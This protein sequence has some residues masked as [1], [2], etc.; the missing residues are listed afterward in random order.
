MMT[1]W[2]F[3]TFFIFP[4]IG[5]NHPNWL[6]FFR[7]VQTTNQIRV[8]LL[9]TNSNWVFILFVWKKMEE[10]SNVVEESRSFL[11]ETRL[12][13]GTRMKS[14]MKSLHWWQ[15][16]QLSQRSLLR[17]SNT[18]GRFRFTSA[19]RVKTELRLATSFRS[20]CSC[21]SRH[22]NILHDIETY[23]ATY[24]NILAGSWERDVVLTDLW[25]FM[26]VSVA[27][28]QL[29]CVCWVMGPLQ[30]REAEPSGAALGRAPGKVERRT[31]VCRNENS[32]N[33]S[34]KI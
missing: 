23:I 6:I 13:M 26:M 14:Y 32:R 29:S 9:W 12:W 19:L 10:T 34:T 22:Y 1:G 8:E 33:Q 25:Y 11:K 18:Q 21:F 15:L 7:G 30:E 31:W 2:W 24:C 17:E 20:F 5:N 16:L 27:F 28:V 3:G 4:Y